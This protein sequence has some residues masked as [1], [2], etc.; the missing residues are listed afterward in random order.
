MHSQFSQKNHFQLLHT[1]V[2]LHTCTP[3]TTQLAVGQHT[4]Q[5]GCSTENTSGSQPIVSHLS[6]NKEQR[7]K[8]NLVPPHKMVQFSY[9][10]VHVREMEPGKVM[11]AGGCMGNRIHTWRHTLHTKH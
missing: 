1:V 9:I 6:F 2:L 5:V 4:Q 3:T 8:G 10:H 11:W 7:M